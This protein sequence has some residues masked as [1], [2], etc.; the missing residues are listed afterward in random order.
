M[1]SIAA[2]QR[3]LQR[4][5]GEEGTEPTQPSA[6]TGASADPQMQEQERIR[7]KVAVGQLAKALEIGT[8]APLLL[9]QDKESLNK[10]MVAAQIG[11][12]PGPENPPKVIPG[13]WLAVCSIFFRSGVASLLTKRVTPAALLNEMG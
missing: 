10:V 12:Y 4:L 11:H 13:C 3:F 7:T 5:T 9:P 8:F 6:G 1:R 2:T